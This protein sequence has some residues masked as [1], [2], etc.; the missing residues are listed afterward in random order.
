MNNYMFGQLQ[1]ITQGTM[2]KLMDLVPIDRSAVIESLLL[3]YFALV[4]LENTFASTYK[5]MAMVANV[6]KFDVRFELKFQA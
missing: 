4:F 2:M 5:P 6:K 1:I 3:K